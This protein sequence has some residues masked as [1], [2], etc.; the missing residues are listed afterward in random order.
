MRSHTR[1]EIKVAVADLGKGFRGGQR[2]AY[3][4][5]QTLYQK[6]IPVWVCAYPDG[7]LIKRCNADGVDS[8]PVVYDAL[9]I[10]PTAMKIAEEMRTRKINIFHASETKSHML[11]VITKLFYPDFKLIVTSRTLMTNP[12]WISR[13]MKFSSPP[14]D[15][16]VAISQAVKDHLQN[17]GIDEKRIV[18]INSG[19]ERGYF[20]TVGR[21]ETTGFV[22]GTACTLHENKG[23]DIIL[24]A[25]GKVRK[26]IG[27][28]RLKI[29]GTGPLEEN[30]KKLSSDLGISKN[31][32]F[33][34]FI[35]E[36]AGFYHSLD[37]YL[38]ASYSESFGSSLNEA[39]ACGAVRVGSRV[40]GIP[41][42]IEDNVNGRLFEAGDSDKLSEIILELGQ[43]QN[44]HLKLKN[45]F[46]SQ[47][48]KYDMNKL[49]DDHIILYNQ[50]L[51]Q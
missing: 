50:L 29:A 22:I 26:E 3:N 39:G 38:L 2:Q 33:L 25:L 17:I 5:A 44:L 40:G 20:N 43:D 34:G 45:T 24:K 37:V 47:I 8:S 6:D 16:F 4:L 49:A 32:E 15:K 12:N 11:G 13:K 31:V 28:F 30:L 21:K 7:D 46:D 42:I 19:I 27:A 36:M 51:D 35:E 1:K 14:V 48:A 23:V 9:K 10:V 18:I 41:E